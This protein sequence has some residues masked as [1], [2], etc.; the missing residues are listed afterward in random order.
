MSCEL[1]L[2]S[3]LHARNRSINFW[4]FAFVFVLSSISC[5][6]KCCRW[7]DGSDSTVR[8]WAAG[9]GNGTMEQCAAMSHTEEKRGEEELLTRQTSSPGF[10]LLIKFFTFFEIRRAMV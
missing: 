10:S 8:N 5:L 3:E 9:E 1:E 7:T 2:G 6:T 4:P